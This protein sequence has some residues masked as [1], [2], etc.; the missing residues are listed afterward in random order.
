[1]INFLASPTVAPQIDPVKLEIQR[2]A[3]ATTPD[4]LLVKKEMVTPIASTSTL[5][6]DPYPTP[7]SPLPYYEIDHPD[8]KLYARQRE[9]GNTFIFPETSNILTPAILKARLKQKLKSVHS[10]SN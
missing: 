4:S 3:R 1:M 10:L 6:T 9:I 8:E 5:K 7:T 2:H